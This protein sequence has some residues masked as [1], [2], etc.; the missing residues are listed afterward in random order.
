MAFHPIELVAYIHPD[1]TTPQNIL[2]AWMTNSQQQCSLI[3][4]FSDWGERWIQLSQLAK[5]FAF[6]AITYKPRKI[7]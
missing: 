3:E 1:G 6:V 7:S 2:A 4:I 5:L